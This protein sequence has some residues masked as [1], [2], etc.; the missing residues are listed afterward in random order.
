MRRRRLTSSSTA[1]SS[2]D[3]PAATVRRRDRAPARPVRARQRGAAPASTRRAPC[4]E[5]PTA[6]RP[7]SATRSSS[8]SSSWPPTSSSEM[9]DAFAATLDEDAAEEYENA[10]D[11]SFREALPGA[12]RRRLTVDALS[13]PEVVRGRQR[14]VHVALRAAGARAGRASRAPDEDVPVP[15]DALEAAAG[16]DRAAR[17]GRRRGSARRPAAGRSGSS[18][19][20][21]PRAA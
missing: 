1:S 21:R 16:E 19:R 14:A 8:T 7:R 15:P 12:P 13:V 11:R 6:T 18:A 17:R 3:L 2:R 5:T 10:F 4:T 9:R 20:A